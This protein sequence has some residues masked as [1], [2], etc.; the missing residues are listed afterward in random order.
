MAM[1]R[2]RVSGLL[3]ILSPLQEKVVRLYFGLGCQRSHSAS[4]IAR[5]FHVAAQVISGILGGAERRLARV[6]LTPSTLREAGALEREISGKLQQER[7][8]DSSLSAMRD[9]TSCD[10]KAP[11]T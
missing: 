9:A 1:D 3:K 5:E 7:S 8:V 4:E 6:G 11:R 10:R 2:N